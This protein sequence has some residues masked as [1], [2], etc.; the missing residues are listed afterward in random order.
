M[1]E[2]ERIKDFGVCVHSG[3][4]HADE[5]L[6]VAFL[7]ATID[8]KIAVYTLDTVPAD[9]EGIYIDCMFGELDHHKY[10]DKFDTYEDGTVFAS[11]G[12]T[13]RKFGPETIGP[14]ATAIL[15]NNFCKLMDGPD[16][17]QG[18]VHNPLSYLIQGINFSDEDNAMD[19]YIGFLTKMMR[20]LIKKV[21]TQ[22]GD[23]KKVHTFIRNNGLAHNKFIYFDKPYV[24]RDALNS[25]PDIQWVIFQDLTGRNKGAYIVQGVNLPDTFKSKAKFPASWAGHDKEYFQSI[26]EPDIIFCHASRSYL[27]TRTLERAIKACNDS[28]S[29]KQ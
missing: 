20:N 24:W 13:V 10:S 2:I 23:E 27:V 29:V 26:G 19:D 15:L 7:R 1:K 6:S 14:K 8:D 5:L 17:G 3:I 11:F 12:K 9:F 4:H 22:A 16:N 25:Y 21:I 28:I 18:N